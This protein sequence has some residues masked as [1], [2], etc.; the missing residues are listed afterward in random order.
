MSC[1]GLRCQRE[2]SDNLHVDDDFNEHSSLSLDEQRRAWAA[3]AAEAEQQAKEQ[4]LAE[5]VALHTSARS[6][7]GYR[8]VSAHYL[9]RLGVFAYDV[10]ASR[11]GGVVL[12]SLSRG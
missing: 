2:T 7:T 1:G 11:G 4:I 8:C 12:P 9:S 6:E 10:K 3:E 5:T